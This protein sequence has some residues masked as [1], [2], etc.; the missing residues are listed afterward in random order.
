[1]K[2]ARSTTL[3]L[4]LTLTF[5]STPAFSDV[6]PGATCKKV[7]QKTVSKGKTYT[8]IKSGKKLIWNKGVITSAPQ[9][10]ISPSPLPIISPTLS[11]APSPTPTP[12]PTPQPT[13]TQSPEPAPSPT[14]TK[15]EIPLTDLSKFQSMSS[16]RISSTVTGQDRQHL[17][18]P[19]SR[20]AIQYLGEHK[21]ITLF[22]YFDD[23][24]AD[25]KQIDEWKNN[26]IPTFERLTE[27]MSYGKLKYKVETL[28]QFLHI[29]KSVLFYNLDTAHDDPMKP[30][31]DVRGLIRDAVAVADPF[32]DFSKYQ[33]VNVVTAPT[34]KIGFEGVFMQ[35]GLFTADGVQINNATFG[36]IRE[37]VDDPLKKIWLLHEVGHLWGLIH[38]F[39]TGGEKWGRPGYPKFSAM[40]NG[41]SRAPEFLAWEKFVLD[42]FSDEQVACISKPTEQTY[43]VKISDLSLNT[44]EIK[45]LIIKLNNNESV[46]LESRRAG[47]DSQLSKED[48][49]IFAYH[50]DVDVK[51]NIGA[52]K[53]IYKDNPPSSGWYPSTLHKADKATF[54]N[55]TIEIL[56]SDPS[57][58]TVKISIG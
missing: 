51:T 3:C 47:R 48:E 56:D 18:F 54:R 2:L 50:V 5:A 33:F 36:P 24:P 15:S 41:I 14:Q 28:D 12:T 43:T 1:M 6:K 52:V 23:L 16:C 11:P 57:D 9:P 53:V 20:E 44:S 30:N 10:K 35:P 58:E 42:W 55:Y 4:V 46:V 13:I 26:Q 39:Q 45:M 31:A 32:V 27:S 49:G 7:G 25:Q 17:G 40:A 29:K 34:T 8:C 22:V 19:R 21:A 37:Y 38:P